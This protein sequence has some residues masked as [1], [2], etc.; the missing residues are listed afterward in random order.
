MLK[1][2]LGKSGYGKT[3]TVFADIKNRINNENK[4]LLIVPEQ[5]S[6][7]TERKVMT[8]LGD[9][10]SANVTVTSFSRFSENI[11]IKNGGVSTRHADD[12]TKMLVMSLMSLLMMAYLTKNLLN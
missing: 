10:G 4:V 5:Y 8:D 11:L 9:K 2:V 3:E 6:Y 12:I 1:F 7:E